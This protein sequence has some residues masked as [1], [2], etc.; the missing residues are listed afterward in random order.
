M[1]YCQDFHHCYGNVQ[2]V[3]QDGGQRPEAHYRCTPHL[4][5][6][7]LPLKQIHNKPRGK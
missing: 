4:C 6:S 5:R 2:G 3:L 7:C 1:P